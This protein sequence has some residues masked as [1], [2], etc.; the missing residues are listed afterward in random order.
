MN[1]SFKHFAMK[2]SLIALVF[3]LPRYEFKA[4]Q[5]GILKPLEDPVA[6]TIVN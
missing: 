3:T 5:Q 2:I 6:I 1:P 4:F